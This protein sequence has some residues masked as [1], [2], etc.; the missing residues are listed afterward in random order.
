M[1]EKIKNNKR[2]KRLKMRIF[3][4]I[5]KAD[6][7]F[8]NHVCI[9]NSLTGEVFAGMPV[10]MQ[11]ICDETKTEVKHYHTTYGSNF[12][13]LHLET[14]VKPKTKHD[15]NE[16]NYQRCLPTQYLIIDNIQRELIN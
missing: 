10:N 3:E 9:K 13:I 8:Y 11:S 16:A 1:T 6:M 15:I 12:S 5:D 2:E 4:K 7:V 14:I